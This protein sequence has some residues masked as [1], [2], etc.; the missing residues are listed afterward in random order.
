MSTIQ[1][2]R[3]KNQSKDILRDVH[4]AYFAMFAAISARNKSISANVINEKFVKRLIADEL[5]LTMADLGDMLQGN[6]KL[7]QLRVLQS[8]TSQIY[9]KVSMAQEKQ[10]IKICFERE[11]FLQFSS[12]S[13]LKDHLLLADLRACFSLDHLN[14]R[15]FLAA[16]S[17]EAYDFWITPDTGDSKKIVESYLDIRPSKLRFVNA[18][19]GFST[20]E[21]ESITSYWTKVLNSKPMEVEEVLRAIAKQS[22]HLNFEMFLSKIVNE[23]SIEICELINKL[24]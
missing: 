21:Q 5:S 8:T 24:L 17:Q 16:L 15:N 23:K 9:R 4:I 22:G 19:I 2:V 14:Y 1:K 12:S 13:K 10:V 7:I 18:K 20:P 3:V 11:C 6:Y